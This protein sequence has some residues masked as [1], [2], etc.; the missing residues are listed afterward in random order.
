MPQNQA[1]NWER[2]A[3]SGASLPGKDFR[4]WTPSGTSCTLA[5]GRLRAR[6]KFRGHSLL[7]SDSIARESVEF[8]ASNPNDLRRV[9]GDELCPCAAEQ[10][11]GELHEFFQ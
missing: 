3:V 6:T 11:P 8:E 4:F 1:F 7:G 2:L 5:L 10:P 9:I